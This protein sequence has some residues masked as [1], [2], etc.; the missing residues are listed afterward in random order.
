MNRMLA[1]LVY[2]V[3]LAPAAF[4]HEPSRAFLTLDFDGMEFSGRW[5]IALAD[6]DEAIGLDT[7][8]DREVT[9]QEFEQ[10]RESML[11]RLA[12]LLTLQVGDLRCT[13]DFSQQQLVQHGG[14][15]FAIVDLTGSCPAAGAELALVYRFLADTDPTHEAIVEASSG[16]DATS[17]IVHNTESARIALQ[18]TGP[19]AI[20]AGFVGEGVLHIA[21]GFDHLAFLA[22]LLL[23]VVLGSRRREQHAQ[24]LVWPVLK[25]VT[26]FTLAHTLTLSLA[27]LQ[28]ISLPG[29]MIEIAIAASICVAAITGLLPRMRAI[30]PALA[31]AFGLLHGFG[32]ASALGALAGDRG[33]ALLTLAGFNV[34]VE[35][36]QLLLVAAAMPLLYLVSRSD[37]LR[38][39]FRLAVTATIGLLGFVWLVQRAMA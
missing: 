29:A 35:L 3:L 33:V 13:T 39:P 19:L 26:A 11:V 32:F 17:M 4:A 18:G 2:M 34:G 5:D 27:S 10:V 23:P 21:A 14:V 9:W 16:D 31:F 24:A 22:L 28:V 1:L 37:T 38:E 30:G 25:V 20:M 6:L 8:G 36:G 12:P 15:P 7:N